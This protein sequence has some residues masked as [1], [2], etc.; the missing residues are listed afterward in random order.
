MIDI[1][2]PNIFDKNKIVAGITK[3]N[4]EIFPPYGFSISPAGAF[5]E[6]QASEERKLLSEELKCK[7]PSL[8]KVI[9]QK[10]VHGDTIE[11]VGSNSVEGIGSDREIRDGMI[12]L[13]LGIALCV[14]L[15][16]CAGVMVYDPKNKIIAAV[17]SGWKGSQLNIA[18]KCI[19]ILKSLGSE[20]E[21]L[22][23]WITPSASGEKYEVGYDVARYF[24]MTTKPKIHLNPP[25]S[26]GEKDE[27]W[28]F[29]NKAQIRLR[30]LESGVREE[31]IEISDICT[32]TVPNYHSYR[33]DGDKSGRMGAWI[34]LI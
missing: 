5:D 34:G 12:C 32:I 19:E 29:D 7:Y 33:R 28:L 22:L 8:K 6:I 18:G 23:I 31:N 4:P 1:L 9:F 15:A 3:R 13:E 20:S 2:E 25:L 17:H 16:D 11:I 14:S 10:Q 21:D 30:L 26:N 27:K 24:P